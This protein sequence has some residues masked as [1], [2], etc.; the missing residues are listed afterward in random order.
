MFNRIH[1]KLGTA[2]FI[3]SIVALVAALGGGAYAASGGLTGK[4]KKEV[5]KIAKKYSGKPGA[6]GAA[7]A[8]GPAGPAGAAGKEGP[9]GKEGGA[10]KEGAQGKE[11]VAGKAGE[12]G[13]AGKNGTTGFTKTLP[14]GETEVGVWGTAGAPASVGRLSFPVSFPIPL[15]TAPN[16]V[17]VVHPD[18]EF[19]GSNLTPPNPEPKCP[20]RGGGSFPAPGPTNPTYKPTTP[21]AT[22]GVLCVY[23]D[24]SINVSNSE[25]G[26]VSSP[27][28][29]AGE[30]GG[31]P[32][33]ANEEGASTAG[34]FIAVNCFEEE[35]GEPLPCAINGT[36]AVTAPQ[37]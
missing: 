20:G 32:Q 23:E 2:G 17:V 10:G 37:E 4:Q 35:A 24:Q 36:W 5:E 14:T 30:V 16:E 34:A 3:I 26:G 9:A 25:I 6:A 29:F 15:A 1:R 33:F 27:Q 31:E 7:G 11:G 21:E 18:E 22:E 12:P 8:T 19:D 28:Y 13:K